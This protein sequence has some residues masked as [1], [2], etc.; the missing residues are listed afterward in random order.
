MI[1]I[2]LSSII[3]ITSLP[4]QERSN[5]LESATNSSIQDEENIFN[6]ELPM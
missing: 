3:L 6:L 1:G 2:I 5:V 4:S